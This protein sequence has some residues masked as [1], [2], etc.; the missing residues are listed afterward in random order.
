VNKALPKVAPQ[1]S[2]DLNPTLVLPI[3]T[4]RR[5]PP[6]DRPSRSVCTK[7]PV[8][9]PGFFFV[10]SRSTTRGTKS[11][12][13]DPE[14]VIIV[15]GRAG[16]WDCPLARPVG[17]KGGPELCTLADA[18]QARAAVHTVKRRIR[19]V[20]PAPSVALMSGLKTKGRHMLLVQEFHDNAEQ[21]LRIAERATDPLTKGAWERLAEKWQRL[22]HEE[23]ERFDRLTSH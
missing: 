15:P 9:F 11:I 2:L 10:C 3:G 6:G 16:G 7:A 18:H 8:R 17:V 4:F 20:A 19:N 1:N 12:G 23:A 5:E 22:E 21:C 14:P 13:C